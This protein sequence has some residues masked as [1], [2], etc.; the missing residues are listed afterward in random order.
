MKVNSL[1]IFSPKG[2]FY[3]FNLKGGRNK[4]EINRSAVLLI[5][6]SVCLIIS[7][8]IMIG[9]IRDSETAKTAVAAALT[10]HLVLT[11]VHS[12]DPEGCFYRMM[13]F[14][15]TPEELRQTIVCISAQRLIRKKNGGVGAVFEIVQGE[16]LEAIADGIISGEQVAVPKEMKIE[17]VIK[18][19]SMEKEISH[20]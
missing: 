4:I 8:V 5:K 17:A 2:F 16:L 6:P 11:T 9:E 13:D 7:T 15:I 18:K 20:V 19:Y 14:G 3:D 1:S 12:K 10:G